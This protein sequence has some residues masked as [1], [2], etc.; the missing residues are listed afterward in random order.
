MDKNQANQNISY[1]AQIMKE[2]EGFFLIRG[3]YFIVWA[4]FV[5]MGYIASY[6]LIEV[7]KPQ[8]IVINW[9]IAVVLGWALTIVIAKKEKTPYTKLDSIF[10]SIWI[11]FGVV[12]TLLGFVGPYAGA[13]PGLS[14]MPI[15][16]AL[17]GGNYFVSSKMYK[18]KW[19]VYSAFGW[20]I[21][22]IVLMYL[23]NKYS[24]L[25]SA[26]LMILFQ[27]VP[28]VALRIKYKRQ[29]N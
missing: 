3:I 6:V 7:S 8:Y 14:I 13:L 12:A 5:S 1:I 25:V 20:W 15:I 4:I 2:S 24:F 23:N 18:C 19:F 28:G 26:L 22:A 29:G 11:S 27:L 16:A 17:L 9:I 10:G 21:G